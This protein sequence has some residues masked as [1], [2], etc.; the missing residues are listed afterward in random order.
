MA[1]T[2]VLPT[3]LGDAAARQ[4]GQRHQDDCAAFHHLAPLADAPA[5]VG[6]GG[7]GHLPPEPGQGPGVDQGHLHRAPDR[8]PV[9]T[10]L[11][12]LRRPATRILPE[13]GQHDCGHPHPHFRPLQQPAR[14]DQGTAAPDHRDHQGAPG[15]RA[16]QQPRLRPAGERGRRT[17]RVPADRR[18][19]AGRPGRAADQGVEGAGLLPDPPARDRR[20]RPRVH[21]PRRAAAAHHQPVWL[22]VP[23]PGAAFR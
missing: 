5:A 10:H 4:V 1:S 7:G 15:K 9:A 6:A 13:R 20:L 23:S 8:E 22:A 19:D 12:R 2:P 21:A 17:A 18:P 3:T 14:P 11:C 16:D